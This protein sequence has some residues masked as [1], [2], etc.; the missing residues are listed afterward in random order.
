MVLQYH[1]AMFNAYWASQESD[2]AYSIEHQLLMDQPGSE[3]LFD[4]EL[5]SVSDTPSHIL[6]Q[7]I[8]GRSAGVQRCD[9]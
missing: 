3:W 7:I 4:R 6:Q 2:S 9:G 1:I 5:S 8:P